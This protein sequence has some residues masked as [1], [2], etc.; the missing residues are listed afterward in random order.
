[1]IALFALV[2]LSQAVQAGQT[3]SIQTRIFVPQS[4]INQYVT[5]KTT[6]EVADWQECYA[7]AVDLAQGY[8]CKETVRV[9]VN[10]FLRTVSD[11]DQEIY[12]LTDWQ[13]SE[14]WYKA[15]I[16]GTVNALSSPEPLKGSQARGVP[17]D[18]RD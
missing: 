14:H 6:S 1:M 10:V 2:C 12:L 5:N 13:V 11:T 17:G 4:F 9:Q 7:K 8:Q 18:T 16:K 15:N 3:C